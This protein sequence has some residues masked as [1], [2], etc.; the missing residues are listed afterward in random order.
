MLVLPLRVGDLVGAA[1]TDDAVARVL[2]AKRNPLLEKARADR[3]AQGALAGKLEGKIAALLTILEGRGL[4]PGPGERARL[5]AASDAEVDL[6]LA[7]AAS[8]ESIAALC[9]L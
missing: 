6:W 7:D 3:H 9:K 2:L 1:T 5:Q 8:C 4:P